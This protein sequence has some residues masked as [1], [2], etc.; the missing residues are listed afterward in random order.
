[1]RAADQPSLPIASL[2]V[3]GSP[4]DVRK[5]PLVAPVRPLLNLTEGRGMII[6]AAAP[7]VDA[8]GKLV[9]VLEGGLDAVPEA[10][11]ADFATEPPGTTGSR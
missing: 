3:V 6:H 10:A 2:S 4:V 1:M 11:T 7:I 5:V 9:G 8:G